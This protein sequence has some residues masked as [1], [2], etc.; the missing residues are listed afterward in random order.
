[1]KWFIAAAVLIGFVAWLATRR[2]G[3]RRPTPAFLRRRLQKLTHDPRVADRLV[4][5]ELKRHPEM[6]EVTAIRR[7]IQRLERDRR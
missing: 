6:D 1:V 2:G 7:V 3:K 5:S 4:A